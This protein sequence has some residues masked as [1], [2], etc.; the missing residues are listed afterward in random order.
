MAKFRKKPLE[1]EAEQFWPDKS[2]PRGVTLWSTEESR[3]RDMSFGYVITIHGQRAH[4]QAGDWIVP[5]PDGWHFYPIK[6]D[7]FVATYEPVDAEYTMDDAR[8]HSG[9]Y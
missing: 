7:I 6:N 4:V 9:M 5:E 2:L 8:H 1:V 3:P